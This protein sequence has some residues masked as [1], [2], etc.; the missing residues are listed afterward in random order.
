MA[1]E[2]ADNHTILYRGN[3]LFDDSGNTAMLSTRSL[4]CSGVKPLIPLN[5]DEVTKLHQ[6]ML[7]LPF[8]QYAHK[9]SLPVVAHNGIETFARLVL[10]KEEGTLVLDGEDKG[11]LE[12]I[13]AKMRGYVA[14]QVIDN[15]KSVLSLLPVPANAPPL[16]SAMKAVA[17]ASLPRAPI[18][19]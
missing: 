18:A 6:D 10:G 2:Q 16:T 5:D 7:L 12:E 14:D 4:M 15:H 8:E 9:A 11:A 3:S 1:D 13:C 17:A 19:R